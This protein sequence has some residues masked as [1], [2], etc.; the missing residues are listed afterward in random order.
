MTSTLPVIQ[1]LSRN[2]YEDQYLVS[3]PNALP[4]PELAPASI[5]VKTSILSLTANTLMYGRIGHI[6]HIWDIHPLPASTPA[7]YS[8]PQKFGRIASWGYAIVIESNVSEI[9]VG[10]QVFGFLPIGTLPQDLEVQINPQLPNQFVEVSKQR[11]NVMALYNQYVFYPPVTQDSLEQKQSQGFDALF[12]IFF[13]TSYLINRFIFPWDPAEFVHPSTLDDTWTMEKGSIDDKTIMLVFADSGKTALAFAYLL[14]NGRPAGTRPGMVVGIGASASRA[15][16][17]G[18]GLY[19]KVMTYDSDA[20]DLDLQLGLAP[21]SKV[22]ICEF[23]SRGGA[24]E[25]WADKLRRF[26]ADGKVVQLTVR[27]EVVPDSPEKA[28]EKFLARTKKDATV[29][30]AS[31][32]RDQVLEVLGEKRYLEGLLNDWSL[33]KERGLVKGLHIVWGEG[34]EDVRKG[35]ERLCKGMVGSAQ[36]LVFLLD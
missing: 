36:G 34:M 17:H 2:N 11:E 15:F 10:A 28:T 6:L 31:K 18:T 1:I 23:G 9:E 21:E 20:S 16:A 12:Q 8:E 7:E 3:L 19:D 14:K 27:G 24:A 4:L 26:R 25:R 5:R 30:N 35:W 29:F 22:V 13:T 32:A 33:F